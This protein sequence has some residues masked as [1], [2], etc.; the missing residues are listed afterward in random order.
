MI[1]KS[2]YVKKQDDGYA[3]D[4]KKSTPSPVVD[5]DT[6]TGCINQAYSYD[7]FVD[8]DKPPIESTRL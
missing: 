6:A 2:L 7:S 1:M 3:V 5:A 4:V 8:A